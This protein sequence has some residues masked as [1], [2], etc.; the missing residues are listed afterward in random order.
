[1]EKSQQEAKR[2]EETL[3]A[4]ESVKNLAVFSAFQAIPRKFFTFYLADHKKVKYV[5]LAHNHPHEAQ[6]VPSDTDKDSD[7]QDFI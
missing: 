5:I 7:Q 2:W 6:S 3:M 4:L 1:M